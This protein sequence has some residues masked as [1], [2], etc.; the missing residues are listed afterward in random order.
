MNIENYISTLDTKRF[1]FKIAKINQFDNPP[2]VILEL[3]KNNNIKLVLCKVTI[4]NL[5]L[6]NQLEAL[7]FRIKDIQVTYKFD[8]KNLGNIEHQIN[9]DL[10]IRDY[11]IKDIPHLIEIAS[12]SFPNYGH[13]ANDKKLD[14]EKCNQIYVDWITRSCEDKNVADKI[15]VAEYL[16][17]I[18]GFLSFK[19]YTNG[20]VKYAAGGIGAVA[21]KHRNMNTFRTLTFEALKWGKDIGLEWEEH[22]VLIDNYPV[23]RS[24]I[25]SGFHIYK[26][27]ITMHNWIE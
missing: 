19:I 24:F 15:F 21:K 13:Y 27:F 5:E 3:L 7:N 9:N 22:N 23:N 4:D 14:I 8:L 2:E 20:T 11:T 18:I 26:S 25:K 6:I 12:D 17:E 1:G 16:D 10:I